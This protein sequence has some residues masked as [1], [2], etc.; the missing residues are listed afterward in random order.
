[1][2]VSTPKTF[3]L[4]FMG[5]TMLGRLIDQMFATH[6]HE[7]EE[8]AI[9]Q[10][11]LKTRLGGNKHFSPETPWGNTLPLLHSADLNLLNLET[12]VTTHSEKWPGKVFNYRMHPANIE[13]LK[14]AKVHYA[15]LANNHTLDFL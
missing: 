11:F 6:V 8:A 9:A 2:T 10:A 13:A 7:P 4:N 12:S 14:A 15:G 3:T 5:D 1:M